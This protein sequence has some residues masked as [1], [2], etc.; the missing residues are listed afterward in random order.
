MDLWRKSSLLKRTVAYQ[1]HV[2]FRIFRPRTVISVK[3][4]TPLT[5]IGQGAFKNRFSL[6]IEVSAICVYILKF[7]QFHK[8][9]FLWLAPVVIC[10]IF[11]AVRLLSVNFQL[12]SK[13]NQGELTIRLLCASPSASS[14]I[15]NSNRRIQS[16]YVHFS[17]HQG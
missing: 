16:H 7:L 1:G 15:C 10:V 13:G 5:K 6:A 17:I 11:A 3:N 14:N 2:K 9:G 12:S 8:K 4:Y